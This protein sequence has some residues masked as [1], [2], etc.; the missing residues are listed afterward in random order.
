MSNW[1]DFAT[2]S[3]I[4]PK[5]FTVSED[6]RQ[7]RSADDYALFREA[8]F[9][10]IAD[11]YLKLPVGLN[12]KWFTDVVRHKLASYS[13]HTLWTQQLTFAYHGFSGPVRYGKVI[14]SETAYPRGYRITRL[15]MGEKLSK[16]QWVSW[17]E[18]VTN[19]F[20]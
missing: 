17:R 3:S 1:E 2:S 9:L 15:W 13:N 18:A 14:V 11:H 7:I 4:N 20:D 5:D 16:P 8:T 10:K 6:R 12:S 19:M